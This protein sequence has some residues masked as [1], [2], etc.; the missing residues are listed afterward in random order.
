MGTTTNVYGFYSITLPSDSIILTVSFVGFKPVIPIKEGEEYQISVDHHS[1]TNVNARQ[2]IPFPTQII[3]VD[4]S[5]AIHFGETY[6]DI[7]INFIDEPTSIDYYEVRL[8]SNFYAYTMDTITWEF[9]STLVYGALW[10]NSFDPIFGGKGHGGDNLL[11]S[12]EE[13]TSSDYILNLS[14]SYY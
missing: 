14:V 13:L 7:D 1:F 6:F 8:L 11:I 10:F 3:R 4:T 5:S 2:I 12:D 9:D